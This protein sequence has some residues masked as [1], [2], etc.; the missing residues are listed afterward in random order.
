M[1]RLALHDDTLAPA[2]LSG[3]PYT[4]YLVVCHEDVWLIKLLHRAVEW[5]IL[6]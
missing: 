3:S 1:S 6:V 4:R 2:L 5:V